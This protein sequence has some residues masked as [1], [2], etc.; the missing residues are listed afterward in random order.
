MPC[1]SDAESAVSGGVSPLNRLVASRNAITASNAL[2]RP[3]TFI[4]VAC[5]K[6][7]PGSRAQPLA[8]EPLLLRRGRPPDPLARHQLDTRVRHQPEHG[9]DPLAA[10]LED[11]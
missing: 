3:A 11:D 9:V 10:A 8:A 6:R 2:N 1:A 5:S 4:A 7:V